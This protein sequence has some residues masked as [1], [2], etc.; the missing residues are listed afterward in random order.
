MLNAVHF[1]CKNIWICITFAA[2]LFLFDGLPQVDSFKMTAKLISNHN[3]PVEEHTVHTNDDYILT[4]YRIPDSPKLRYHN[5]SVKPVVFLQHGILCASDDWIINGPETSLAYMFAD[6]GYDVWLGNAR[7]NTYS[8]QHKHKRPDSSDFWN[9]SWHEIGVYDLTAMLDYVLDETRVGSVHFVAHSQGTTTFFVLM[10]SMPWYNEKVRTVHLLAPIAFMRNHSF[11]LSKVG[12]IFL[13]YPSFLSMVL[14][15]FELLPT[16]SVQK[17]FCEYICSPNS[18]FKFL[19]SGIL[20]FIGGWGTRHLNHTLLPHVCE[21]HPAGA[22]T[23]QIIHYLQLYTSGDFKQFDHGI[24]LNL[25]KYNQETPP[26][27]EVSNIKSCVNLYYSNNDYMSAV[28]DV[29]YLASLLPC[30]ELYRM[31]YDDWNHYDFLWSVNVK[32]MINDRIIE[33][34]EHYEKTHD[35]L[36]RI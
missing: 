24:H 22:S 10:S 16:T 1:K 9:F 35:H 8:R 14:A 12:G 26:H 23:T 7:G 3:Y 29:E 18:H 5:V 21:T 2:I 15:G 30:A 34:V 4:M 27:Y 32:E 6:M 25:K 36:H 13:G 33:K 11:L 19:C 31:P 17:L 20:N 28:E